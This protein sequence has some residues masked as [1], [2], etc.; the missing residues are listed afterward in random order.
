MNPDLTDLQLISLGIAVA[1]ATTFITVLILMLVYAEEIRR[2][3]QRLGILRRRRV[4]RTDF[5]DTPFPIHYVVPRF[6]RRRPTIRTDLAS[7]STTTTTR[8][9]HRRAITIWDPSSD[10]YFSSREDL[11]TRNDTGETGA[12]CQSPTPW[13]EDP[14]TSAWH[15]RGAQD[16][17]PWGDA[18]HANPNNNPDYPSGTWNPGDRERAIAQNAENEPV[19]ATNNV[20]IEDEHIDASPPYFTREALAI[21]RARAGLHSPSYSR[22]DPFAALRRNYIPFP[23]TRRNQIPPVPYR[24]WPDKSDTSDSSDEPDQEHS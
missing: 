9:L 11:P 23:T 10:E 16:R 20:Y 12:G 21:P 8:S 19:F 17:D 6:E 2:H 14:G 24:Q 18:M 5:T 1:I 13:L 22:T 4:P 7:I 15:I 3:L